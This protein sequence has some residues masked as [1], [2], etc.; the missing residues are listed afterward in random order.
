MWF[1]AIVYAVEGIGQAKSGIIWQPLTYFLKETQGWDPVKISVSV[2][3]FDLPWIIKPLWGAISDFVPILGYRRR[4]YLVIANVLGAL[5]FARVATLG[6]PGALIP[7]IAL[8]SVAMAISS[9]LCGAL[10][11]ETGQKHDASPGLVNQQWLFFNIAQM[12][13]VLVAGGLIEIFPPAGALHAAALIA[14]AA[15]LSVVASVWLVEEQRSRIDLP[16]LRGRLVAL[17]SAFRNRNLWLVAGF[18]FLY[19]FS[20]GFGTPLYF[21]MTDRLGFSQGFIGA[22]SSIG[23]GGWIVGGAL[24]KWRLHRLSQPA[25]LRLSILGGIVTTLSYLLL[26][27]P[28]SAV[29]IWLMTGTAAMLATIAMMSL[30]AEACPEGAEGFA[31]AGLMSVTNLA[32]PL[33]DTLGSTLYEHVFNRHL[34]PLIIVSAAA[35][36]LV[37]LLIPLMIFRKPHRPAIS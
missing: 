6:T 13:A 25:L 18:L 37:L 31:F 16:A 34:T 19:Y 17:L 5:A 27:G 15:P 4:P 28:A 24:Y 9:T 1:F 10:L 3:I 35:T 14:A 26:V 22:L 23:A 33:G 32:T 12:A 21:Q 20:P 36:A 7:A 8:T 29:A 11:V 2:A 30:A